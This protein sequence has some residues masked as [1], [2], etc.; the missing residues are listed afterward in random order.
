MIFLYQNKR[1]F[2]IFFPNKL[3]GIK[4]DYLKSFHQI[5][6]DTMKYLSAY[7]IVGKLLQLLRITPENLG[8]VLSVIKFTI[9]GL[10]MIVQR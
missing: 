9:H 2:L 5:Q 7:K 1:S 6:I 3:L 8:L 10:M 4:K